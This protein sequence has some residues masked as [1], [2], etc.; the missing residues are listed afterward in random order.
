M[1]TPLLSKHGS[2]IFN[3][4]GTFQTVT[5][6]EEIKQRVHNAFLT[7]KGSDIFV[8]EYGFDLEMFHSFNYASGRELVLQSLAV[9]AMNPIYLNGISYLYYLDTYITGVT[10]VINIGITMSD[11]S[12]YETNYL[13]E[14]IS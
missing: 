13:L 1:V 5:G 11:G 14:S 3:P 12:S 9:E 7:Q 8:P 4:D 2:P 6:V 10:G